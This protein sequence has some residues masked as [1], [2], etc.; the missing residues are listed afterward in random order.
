MSVQ[1]FRELTPRD[2]FGLTRT[3]AIV[4]LAL[5]VVTETALGLTGGGP[6]HVTWQAVVSLV[7]I[8]GS[9][10]VSLLPGAFPLG[11]ASTSLILVVVAVTTL[12]MSWS[13]PAN[14]TA[15]TY[16]SWQL[17]A[18]TFLLFALALR[19]RVAWAWIGMG[20]MSAITVT[21]TV[22]TGQ[23]LLTGISLVDRQWGTLVLG[24]LFAIALARSARSIQAATDAENKRII[25]AEIVRAGAEERTAHIQRLDELAAPALRQIAEGHASTP[26]RRAAYSVLEASLRDQLRAAALAREPLLSSARRARFRG[27]DVILLDDSASDLLDDALIDEVTAWMAEELDRVS[28]DTFTARLRNDPDGVTATIVAGERRLSRRFAL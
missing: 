4:L 6:L 11:A 15:F 7:L 13:L 9:A 19:G 23:G 10:V 22:T 8:N 1:R 14:G 18:N 21:W 26:L 2:L 5:F 20:V 3:R 16:S 25:D 12:I 17:G 24:T 27:V 28:G